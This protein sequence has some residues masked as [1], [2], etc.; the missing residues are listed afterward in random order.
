MLADCSIRI[1]KN[2][3]ACTYS[4]KA[5]ALGSSDADAFLNKHCR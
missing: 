2:K 4:N 5:K 3:D 1:G